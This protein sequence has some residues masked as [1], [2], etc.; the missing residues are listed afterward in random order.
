MVGT[1]TTKAETAQETTV[2]VY[3]TGAFHVPAEALSTKDISYNDEVRVT[4][5]TPDA[6]SES[7]TF[8]NFVNAGNDVTIPAEVRRMANIQTGTIV[9]VSIEKTGNVWGPEDGGRKDYRSDD[10][11]STSEK[12][13]IKSDDLEMF[14]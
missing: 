12:I 14:I 10:E 4:V 7:V 6:P 1:T 5:A 11:S 2:S 13:T 8:T 9:D 3:T